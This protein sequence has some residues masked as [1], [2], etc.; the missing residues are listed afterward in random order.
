MK[1]IFEW[2]SDKAQSNFQKHGIRFDEAKTIFSDPLL[3]TYPDDFHSD[4]EERFLSIGYSSRNRL[5]LT[6]HTER[7]E[8]ETSIIIRIISCRKA[9][10]KE[11]EFYE[12][13]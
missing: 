3:L 13:E 11:R 8:T 10:N 12:E 9:T 2:D 5:L 4:E 6:V 7:L 1:I